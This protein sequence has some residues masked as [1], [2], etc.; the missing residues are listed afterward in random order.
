MEAGSRVEI[1]VVSEEA[2][3]PD[4]MPDDVRRSLSASPKRLSSKY[5]YDARGSRLFERITELPEYY[6]TRAEQALLESR[7]AEIASLTEMEEL[8]ELG[9]GA[10]KKTRLLIEAGLEY[11]SLRRF[12][13][14]EVSHKMA[15]TAA[16]QLADAYRSLHV[17]AVVADFLRQL[18]RVP[19]GRRRLVAL[20]GSTI[21]NFSDD[22]AVALL[23]DVPPL[24]S[25]GG[26]FLMGTDLVKDTAVLEAA[27]NDSQGV[28][29]EFNRNILRVVNE[30]L[31]G[32]FDP[33]AFKHVARY[34]EEESRIESGLRSIRRQAMRLESID[35]DVEFEEGELLGTE[36]SCKYTRESVEK[37]LADAGLTLLHWFTDEDETYGLSLSVP[38]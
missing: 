31:D 2:D 34:N 32:D 14:V 23:A 29:A 9:S 38:T 18:D 20:L 35:L 17:R 4:S 36:I 37:L 21:G 27:Y 5:F 30:H 8:V 10:A 19:P 25:G 7:V 3:T 13:A 1:H 33:G 11:G 24:L 26:F 28:T 12:T 16:E 22:E 6:L 15:Q